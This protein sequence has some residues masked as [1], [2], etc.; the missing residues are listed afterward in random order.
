MSTANLSLLLDYLNATLTPDN[1]RWM[2]SQL[3]KQADLQ[4][5]SLKPYTIEE[6]DAIIDEA[7][8]EIA[9]GEGTPHEEVM[10]EWDEEIA[11]MEEE[12]LEI[13]EAV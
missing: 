13:A 10:R 7:E 1:M 9:A 4:E 5:E 6:I 12:E 11:H 8:A 2:A 3:A